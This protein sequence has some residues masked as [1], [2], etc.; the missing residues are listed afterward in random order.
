[1]YVLA[2][3]SVV[4]LGVVS[5]RAARA[6]DRRRGVWTAAIALLVLTSFMLILLGW[7]TA[8]NT[9][10]GVLAGGFLG[11]SVGLLAR[12]WRSSSPVRRRS[13]MQLLALAVG[14]SCQAAARLLPP[15]V[16]N[17]GAGPGGSRPGQPAVVPRDAVRRTPSHPVEPDMTVSGPGGVV[18]VAVAGLVIIGIGILTWRECPIHLLVPLFHGNRSRV[19]RSG[20]RRIRSGVP[21]GSIVERVRRTISDRL[22]RNRWSRRPDIPRRTHPWSAASTRRRGPKTLRFARRRR[23]HTSCRLRLLPQGPD[24]LA[25]VAGGKMAA[26]RAPRT[27]SRTGP[28]GHGGGLDAPERPAAP[29]AGLKSVT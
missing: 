17:R 18:G 5:V 28:C 13:L 22:V 15:P 2:A 21:R 24:D 8:S 10:F 29:V 27:S 9:L 26:S 4:A 16:A 25:A 3:A 20:D 23:R 7:H 14:L 1:M 11:L 12:R 19:S 6:G